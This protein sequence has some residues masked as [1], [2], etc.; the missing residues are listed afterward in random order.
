M[1]ELAASYYQ[2]RAAEY[3]MDLGAILLS[4]KPIEYLHFGNTMAVHAFKEGY[5]SLL[6]AQLS[7]TLRSSQNFLRAA[8]P[9]DYPVPYDAGGSEWQ[10]NNHCQE[11]VRSQIL[12]SKNLRTG[13]I[14]RLALEALA[15]EE[16]DDADL[17]SL[18]ERTKG[19][20]ALFPGDENENLEAYF[21][22]TGEV[23]TGA[24]NLSL[25]G[26]T[27]VHMIYQPG[28]GSVTTVF[29]GKALG[30]NKATTASAAR[31]SAA[32]ARLTDRPAGVK[33][34]GSRSSLKKPD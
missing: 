12:A 8:L 1:S 25:Y 15:R 26:L 10:N 18:R 5:S 16:V 30:L 27:L 28:P 2:Q 21:Q 22:L 32:T 23:Q 3:D 6:T 17:K 19:G 4:G 29:R 20:T 13:K 7:R 14:T 33:I 11:M 24:R 31:D 9:P 34:R